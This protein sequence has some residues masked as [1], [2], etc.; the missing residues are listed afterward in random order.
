MGLE[1]VF[2][3]EIENQRLS[4]E[5]R[6]ACDRLNDAI[7]MCS[8]GGL[9]VEVEVIPAADAADKIIRNVVVVRPYIELRY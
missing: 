3:R 9:N 7:A 4:G 2:E 6:V 1:E 5:L 8:R